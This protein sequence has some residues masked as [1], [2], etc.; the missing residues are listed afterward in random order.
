[1]FGGVHAYDTLVDEWEQRKGTGA[2]ELN[3]FESCLDLYKQVVREG[4]VGLED[5]RRAE[6]NRQA[7]AAWREALREVVREAVEDSDVEDLEPALREW[8]EAFNAEYESVREALD[9]LREFT[10]ADVY[11]GWHA[12]VRGVL[13]E[14]DVPA[15][16]GPEGEA[17]LPEDLLYDSA[18][19]YGENV[20][21]VE[22]HK[23]GRRS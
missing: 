22:A 13:D 23:R 21:R 1:M 8:V 14:L 15:M 2:V 12:E 19:A 20:A 18:R 10:E 11:R 5:E 16:E 17:E 7:R 3:V 9:R 6:K 4:L